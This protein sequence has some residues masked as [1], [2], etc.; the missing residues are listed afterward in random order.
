MLVVLD[1]NIT[2]AKHVILVNPWWN[3]PKEPICRCHRY[4]Q[5]KIVIVYRIVT[6]DF[7][8]CQREKKDI[9]ESVLDLIAL[10]P[11]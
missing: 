11:V 1:L 7:V 8:E 3:C 5:D 10:L 2:T 4:D 6:Q 9:I